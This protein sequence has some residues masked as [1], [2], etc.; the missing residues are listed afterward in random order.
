MFCVADRIPMSD[1]FSGSKR[2]DITRKVYNESEK[3]HTQSCIKAHTLYHL[4]NY[5]EYEYHSYSFIVKNST[6]ASLI[7]KLV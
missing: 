4:I 1:D 3:F 2:M 7:W 6:F 5:L